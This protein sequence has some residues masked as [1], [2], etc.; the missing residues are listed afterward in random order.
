M[1]WTVSTN[2]S[3]ITTVWGQVSGAKQTTVKTATAKNIGKAN[4]TSAEAQALIEATAMW[5]HKVDRRYSLTP[6][7]AEIPVF[8][9][10]LAHDVFK[11]L[12]KLAFPA[13]VQPKLDGFRCLT[14]RQGDEITCYSRSGKVFNL[15]HLKEELT[16]L[17]ADGDVFDGELYCHGVNFNTLAS[18]VKRPQPS[19]RLIGY[20]VY[21]LPETITTSEAPQSERFAELLKRFAARPVADSAT[22]HK[23]TMVDCS[24]VNERQGLLTAVGEY[25][26]QGYEG[27]MYRSRH[28]QYSYGYRS[29][30][31]LKI[32]FFDEEDFEI[33]GGTSGIGKF[34]GMCV[35]TCRTPEGRLFEAMPQGTAAMRRKYLDLLPKLVGHQLKVKFFGKSADGIPRFPV[36]LHVRHRDLEG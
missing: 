5:R 10:M 2:G 26:A 34:T 17:M 25:I 33:V 35:F 20:H 8:L 27:G 3:D 18:W 30:D 24:V 22:K 4:Y 36:G 31:L 9:P 21:D 19:Q 13:F 14:R 16:T 6:E 29:H 11:H 1:I 32:K 7:A 23:V 28:G 15:P 12:E